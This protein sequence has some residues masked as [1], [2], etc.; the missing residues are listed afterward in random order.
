[1]EHERVEEED[2]AFLSC[3]FDELL[4]L[5]DQRPEREAVLEGLGIRSFRVIF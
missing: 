3:D 1:V 5:G 2:V 4:A